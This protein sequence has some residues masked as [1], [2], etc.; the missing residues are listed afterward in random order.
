MSSFLKNNITTSLFYS[1]GKNSTN[2][3]LSPIPSSRRESNSLDK[4]TNSKS[5]YS[6][7]NTIY[8][9]FKIIYN[10]EFPNILLLNSKLFLRNINEKSEKLIRNNILKT[11]Y[12]VENIKS[13]ISMSEDKI[14]NLYNEEFSF[15]NETFFNY[16]KNPKKYLFLKCNILNHCSN[17]YDKYIYHKCSE[18]KYGNFISVKNKNDNI[19]L[20]CS[21]CKKCYKN[22]YINLYCYP[23]KKDYYGFIYKKNI[24]NNEDI[25]LATWKKYHC[26]ILFNEIMK[27]I[28]CKNYFYYNI[29]TNK[30]ICQNRKCN[31]TSKP[32]YII[33]K[34]SKCSKDFHSQVKPFNPYEYRVLK[35]EINYIVLNRNKAKPL[36]LIRCPNCEK[37]LISDKLIFEHNEKCKGELFKGKLFNKDIIA[38]S[39]CLYANYLEEFIWTCPLCNKEINNK[40]KEKDKDQGKDK[41]KKIIEK[42]NNINNTKYNEKINLKSYLSIRSNNNKIR[43]MR[44]NLKNEKEKEKETISLNNISNIGNKKIN[45]YKNKRFSKQIKVLPIRNILQLD[46]LKSI[47]KEDTFKSEKELMLKTDIHLEK[48]TSN[49][50]LSKNSLNNSNNSILSNPKYSLKNKDQKTF[51]SIIMK[52]KNRMLNSKNKNKYF[53]QTEEDTKSDYENK[54]KRF[55]KAIHNPNNYISKSIDIEKNELK[56]EIQHKI[57]KNLIKIG[58]IY[59]R[60]KNEIK[61]NKRNFIFVRKAL[62]RKNS[63]EINN[64]VLNTTNENEENNTITTPNIV[65]SGI[66]NKYKDRIQNYNGI[67]TDGNIY[68][69]EKIIKL[70]HLYKRNIKENNKVDIIENNKYDNEN[71]I[72]KNGIKDNIIKTDDINNNNKYFLY[73]KVNN[74]DI[75][76][77]NNNNKFIVNS[78]KVNKYNDFRIN[79][80]NNN[81]FNNYISSKTIYN[82]K[83]SNNNFI[84]RNSK[85]NSNEKEN[86]KSNNIIKINTNINKNE[87][88]NSKKNNNFIEDK[89]KTINNFNFFSRRRK[90][91]H[92]MNIIPSEKEIEKIEE[93]E[94]KEKKEEKIKDKVEIKKNIIDN[95]QFNNRFNTISKDRTKKYDNSENNQIYYSNT[96]TKSNNLFNKKGNSISLLIRK[97]LDEFFDNEQNDKNKKDLIDKKETFN[98]K[99]SKF[100]NNILIQNIKNNEI[101]KNNEN[102]KNNKNNNGKNEEEDEYCNLRSGNDSLTIKEELEKDDDDID[103]EK[104]DVIND[105][106]IKKVLQHFARRKSVVSILREIGNEDNT[107]ANNNEN[108][109]NNHLVLEGL[110]NHVNL[111]SSPEKITLLEQN[112]LIP[113]FSDN[114]YYYDDIIG[115][116]SNANVYLVKDNKTN[117]EF[118][119]KKMVCQEFDDLVKIKKKLEIINSL[120]HKNI[121]KVHK[122]QFKCLDFTTYA[123]NTVMDLAIADWNNEIKK[124]AETNNFYTEKE[125]IN[126]A[127]HIIDGLAF[128]QKKNIA[129]RDIKPQNILIFPNKVYKIA[130]LGEMMDDIKNF[131]KLLTIRGSAHFLS[132]ALKNGLKNNKGG[133]KHNAYKSDVFSLGYCFL[134][135][136]SLNLEVLENARE[137]WGDKNYQNI[138]IDVKKYIG[139]DKYSNKLFDFIGKMIVENEKE[140]EDFIGLIKELNN[141]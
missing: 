36:N 135:A 109:K 6:L 92:Y 105:L 139:K 96:F 71:K 66:R 53:N 95:N 126:I 70:G 52:M 98:L 28:N 77:D 47:E 129:H 80:A 41:E 51:H 101:K 65:Y 9:I 43:N 45:H 113:I 60:N 73:K 137:F 46:N 21:K 74:R 85:I 13:M 111:M 114:D 112:S 82:K 35:N 97:N 11:V 27:C 61:Q 55:N 49:F 104:K 121:M 138:E 10:K 140:R 57:N 94:E 91:G 48:E 18:G 67:K 38:C 1:S 29:K 115:E 33:W 23:C 119:I 117:K 14:L 32:E 3:I 69:K 68:N 39:K 7:D 134:Y 54:K 127:K 58:D 99:Q 88:D 76:K 130:D 141:L 31:F 30:L 90:L 125:I 37:I 124:R 79:T 62:T 128:L 8:N 107:K 26:C 86:L 132:P 83:N 133:V 84:P 103:E 17:N 123:I 87:I 106:N 4:K 42:Y 102:N 2:D 93:K 108:I 89:K 34:C 136:M 19:Y 59:N 64:I 63:S 44:N 5:K 20:I 116:G 120:N 75:S 15:L 40:E 100:Y 56:K 118:A 50:S 12:I 81:N 25:Y 22:N 78:D 72:N 110:I 131:E 122:I 16:Q 24:I